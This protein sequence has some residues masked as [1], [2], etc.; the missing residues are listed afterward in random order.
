M[1]ETL[2]GRGEGLAIDTVIWGI[3]RLLGAGSDL[4]SDIC[5]F[6]ESLILD[7]QVRYFPLL[8][9]DEFTASTRQPWEDHRHV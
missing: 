2:S 3:L 9:D 8:V 7:E 4:A 1:Q 6:S 5:K